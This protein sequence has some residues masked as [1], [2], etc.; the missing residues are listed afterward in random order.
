MIVSHSRSTAFSESTVKRSFIP[1]RGLD[2]GI[3]QV[4][5]SCPGLVAQAA[6]ENIFLKLVIEVVSGVMKE[7]GLLQISGT[8]TACGQMKPRYQFFAQS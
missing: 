4:L 5:D 7:L 8:W 6:G 2:C 3:Q 1:D